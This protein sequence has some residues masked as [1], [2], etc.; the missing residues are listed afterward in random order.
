MKKR[1]RKKGPTKE[2][3]KAKPKAKKAQVMNTD[4]ED[5]PF[6]EGSENDENDDEEPAK[7]RPALQEVSRNNSISTS[8]APSENKRVIHDSDA[9]DGEAEYKA[10]K[11]EAKDDED[12]SAPARED[13]KKEE[14][15]K[16]TTTPAAG[17]LTTPG[18]VTYRVGL[19]RRSRIPS[20]LKVIR[21][22]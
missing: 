11:D 12:V 10:S 13:V 22:D 16:P 5:E 15:K 8:R 20:L 21:K 9:S 14:E 18:K 19:S 3:P 6:V 1:G 2:T 4:D 7:K 17:K